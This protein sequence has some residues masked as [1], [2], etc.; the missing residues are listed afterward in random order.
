[1]SGKEPREGHVRR[2]GAVGVVGRCLGREK[3]LEYGRGESEKDRHFCH[4][5]GETF[6]WL[7]VCPLLD[8]RFYEKPFGDDIFFIWG[9]LTPCLQKKTDRQQKSLTPILLI[10]TRPFKCATRGSNPGHPD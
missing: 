2:S 3:V 4:C 7:V 5:S 10:K 9:M 6:S 8:R 1:M